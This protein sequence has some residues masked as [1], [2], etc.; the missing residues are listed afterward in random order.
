MTNRALSNREDNL[1]WAIEQGVF[2]IY[3]PNLMD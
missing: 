2:G 3:L 1:R